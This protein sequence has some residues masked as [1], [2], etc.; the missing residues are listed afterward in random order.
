VFGDI[1][2]DEH[3]EWCVRVCGEAGAT[4]VHPLWKMD[5]MDAVREFLGA[6]F[7]AHIVAMK[8]GWATVLPREATRAIPAL[9]PMTVGP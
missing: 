8:T 1:D 6:G 7:Q 9:A 5:R 4:A 2:L 3:L